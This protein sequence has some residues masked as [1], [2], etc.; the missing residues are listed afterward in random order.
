[1][2]V[3]P[4]GNMNFI[5]QNMAYPS[6]QMSNEIAKEGFAAMMN[7]NEFNEKEKIVDKLQKVNQSQEIDEQ[8]KEKTEEEQEKK[9]KKQ[10][11]KD[12]NDNDKEDEEEN[13]SSQTHHLDLSI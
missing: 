7:L 6:T 11:Q 1:M 12:E 8:V 13:E 10:E 5:N 9:H 4:I 2:P 3:S